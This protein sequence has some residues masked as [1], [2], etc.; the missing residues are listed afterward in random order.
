[1]TTMIKTRRA[2]G[3]AGMGALAA[4]SLGLPGIARAALT[5]Q[6]T[7]VVP[8]APGTT[9]QEMRALAPIISRRV[10]QTVVV[11]NRPGAGGAVGARA[12]SQA[13]PDGHTM[14]YAAAAVLNVQPLMPNAAYGSDA[15]VP[16]A[17]VSSN[18]QVI[19]CRAD[20]PWQTLRDLLD[21]ARANPGRLNFSSAGV[22]TA[23]HMAGEAVA[24]VAGVRVT[25]VPFQGAAPAITSVVA[26]NTDFTLGLPVAVMPHVSTG[27][28]RALA[29]VGPER[30]PVV[31][32]V[33][34]LRE[35]GLDLAL[36]SDIGLFAPRGTP[37]S[38]LD[39]WTEAARA[40]V[41]SPEFREFAARARV[42][43]AFLNRAAFAAEVSRD[44]AVYER[45]IPTLTL[46]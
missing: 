32:E 4:S 25:H 35:V 16:V 11:D 29:Q 6:V 19:A 15:L 36:G 42:N 18:T 12:V 8:Y 28:L 30:S 10:G 37:E 23:V 38:I 20:A 9:D 24:M 17:R 2:L 22:G 41:E 14:L 45:L 40:A 31:P 5:Q 7:V 34:T 21:F 43:A 33:P 1:M 39:F 13:R 44:R 26:G 3:I 46:S 27:R